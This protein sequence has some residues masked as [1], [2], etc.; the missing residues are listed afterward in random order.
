[1]GPSE[2]G[3]VESIYPDGILKRQS[4]RGARAKKPI[5]A[6]AL[7]ETGF[8][9]RLQDVMRTILVYLPK[10]RG[11]VDRKA[12]EDLLK[13]V[14][15]TGEEPWGVQQ[16]VEW[17]AGYKFPS[18]IADRDTQRLEK[19]GWN[20]EEMVKSLHDERSSR[21]LNPVRVEKE[22][23]KS[24]L[25][26]EKLMDLATGGLRILT[27]EGFAPN[28]DPGELR[29]KYVQAHPAVNKMMSDLWANENILILKTEDVLEHQHEWGGA[30]WS[31]THWT[32]KQGKAKGRP[33]GD[34][35]ATLKSDEIKEAVRERYGPIEHPTIH[36]MI[37]LI[38]EMVD[39]H[40]W[41]ALTLMK[42]DLAG[43]FTLLDVA[44]ADVKLLFCRLT[45]DL[46]MAYHTGMFGYT[47]MPFAFD[48][49]TRVL[50]RWAKELI[51]GES[52][53]YADD[54]YAAVLIKEA[55]RDV[56]RMKSKVENIL[57]PGSIADEKTEISRRL[58]WIGWVI[59]LDD[60]TVGIA[61]HNMLKA[62]YSYFAINIS[63][64]VKVK[65][66][67]AMAS[68]GSRYALICTVMKPFTGTLYQEIAGMVNDEATK[69]LS[70]QAR[71]SVRLW[72]MFLAMMELG[73]ARFQR[74]LESFR[75]RSLS[76]VIESD[77]S[78]TGIGVVIS[79]VDGDREAV[80][81]ALGIALP[82]DL[83]GESRFQN[84]LEF[85]GAVVGMAMLGILGIRG[86]G[87]KIRGDNTAALAWGETGN[88]KS[89]LSQKS[90][91]LLVKLG[92]K[93]DLQVIQATHVPGIQNSVCDAL[94]R[95]SRP[96]TLRI[97]EAVGANGTERVGHQRNHYDE[98]IGE[99][100]VDEVLFSKEHCWE[101]D[102][103]N[104]RREDHISSLVRICDPREG[105]SMDEEDF[106]MAWKDIDDWVDN[107]VK[108]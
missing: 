25:D 34:C 98:L 30:N 82:Y 64:P 20:L 70:K 86:A 36:S 21:R 84:T 4:R 46:C 99:R 76:Y 45:D 27:G 102:D 90:S 9:E 38:L 101:H 52:G 37:L 23:S 35:T 81:K 19:A 41:E 92:L 57:G 26:Y 56:A 59:N 29:N 11:K 60:R 75:L 24:D 79:I 42:M 103:T 96:E 91:L 63:R 78:L 65:D 39:R 77:A 94:S 100:G 2:G 28:N 12:L 53:I 49:V 40:G 18:D 43:A 6:R 33:I 95:G 22:L 104:G 80:W 10:D 89:A 32:T 85:T 31:Q 107:A 54:I 51:S 105:V 97:R 66:I 55:L 5:A 61:R 93:T 68:R 8:E 69:S 16:A 50:R 83:K 15:A 73:G 74:P 7:S 58:N 14:V 71:I 44:P 13:E 1:V 17:A 72:R 87:V 47:G 3:P 106:M 62:L 88:F 67:R 48:V 108:A